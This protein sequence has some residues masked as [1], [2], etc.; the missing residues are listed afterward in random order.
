M[1]ITVINPGL[2]TTVQDLSRDGYAHFGISPSGAADSSSLRLGNIIVGNNKDSAGLEMT[3]LGGTF[4]F[5]SDAIIAITGSRFQMSLDN[6]KI[7]HQK[8]IYIKK[9]QTLSIGETQEGARC[10]LSVKG[11]I[12]VN[13]YLS[14][15][16]THVMSRLGGYRGRPIK[17]DDKIKIGNP[18]FNTPKID[19]DKVFKIDRT[20]IKITK[21]L[22]SD[23]FSDSCWKQFLSHT[24]T[25]SN[26]Y[27]RMGI[28]LVENKIESSKGNEIL[29]EGIPN[30]AIQVPANGEPI[31]TFV[32][33]QTTGGYPK[34]ANVITSDLCKVGQLKPNDKF[35]FQLVSI[36][37]AEN[38][39][40]KQEAFFQQI[41][42]Y[43]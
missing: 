19:F 27:S 7:P 1:S 6:D 29:T 15:K 33:H 32:E 39:R 21:G 14:G 16:T 12:K 35:K 24:F 31:I 40:I 42:N 34:I 22:Q 36:E 5:S 11:G 20:K 30:G 41:E 26:V 18:I 2:Q 13:K 38:F 43:E 8:R 10:Y 17:K 37:E 3:I 4:Q 25:V 28:R 9:G 23:W